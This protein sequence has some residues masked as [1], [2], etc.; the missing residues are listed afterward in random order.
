MDNQECIFLCVIAICMSL[1]LGV[2]TPA[3]TNKMNE[4]ILECVKAGQTPA[5]CKA[6]FRN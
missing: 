2:A 4:K 6:A 1:M 3:C 5:E